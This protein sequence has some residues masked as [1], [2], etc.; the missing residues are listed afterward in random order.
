MLKTSILIFYT[1][2][3]EKYVI[4]QAPMQ[5]MV[6][7]E[8]V[9]D[10]QIVSTERDGCQKVCENIPV[11]L[12]GNKVDVKNRQVKAK[13]VTFHRK[14]NLQ[15]YEISAKSNYN[16]EKPFLY[17]AR[18]LAGD[19]NLHF[20]ESAARAPPEVQIDIAAQQLKSTHSQEI[21][22]RLRL[23]GLGQVKQMVV[24]TLAE[25]GMDLSD[26]AKLAE[27]LEMERIDTQVAFFKLI[28]MYFPTLY[29][30]E[31]LMKFCNSLHGGL[32]KLA[33]LLEMERIDICHQAGSD[34]LLTS[35]TF[36]KLKEN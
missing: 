21:L 13:Q 12:C 29:D 18:K 36:R 16:F 3:I 27:L 23:V 35:F 8:N 7:I 32:N 6:K 28:K 14:K 2:E 10:D 26:E 1:K 9:L 25:S 33:E 34:S 11:V 20:V 5:N 30:I 19:V 24:A 15:Y 4:P 31:H 17:L 22:L